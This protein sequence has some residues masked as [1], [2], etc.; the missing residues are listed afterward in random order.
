[1]LFNLY[2]EAILSEALDGCRHG[3]V[4]NGEVINN[5]RYADD[6]VL[7][8]GTVEELQEL[9]D[10]VNTSSNEYGL[11]MNVRKTKF[12]VISKDEGR[13]ALSIGGK[14]I[15][16]VK[17]YKYLGCYLNEKWDFSQEIKAR[18]EQARAAFYKMKGLLCQRSL[19]LK[20]RLRILKC[21]VVPVLMYG[22]E[23]WTL[24][25]AME[26]RLTAFEMWLYRR[27]LR[28]PWT[29]RIRNTE[30]LSRMDTEVQILNT[31]KSQ[32]LQYFAHVIRNEKY[33]L[34]QLIMEGKIEGKRRPGRRKTSWL[35]NLR[36]WFG[37]DSKSLFRAAASKVR[38]VM[39]IANLR[40]GGDI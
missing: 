16:K 11:C 26:K 3:I 24:T 6:T 37:M 23:G 31:V 12:M 18:I 22:H 29:D 10:R 9:M 39:M 20:T 17:T 35:K 2:S 28:I 27:M 5:L 19:T 36:E 15:E 33:R 4:V 8:A 30:V 7:I 38:I 34:L 21:Y 13:A 32:K 1:M 25:K 14:T 40:R